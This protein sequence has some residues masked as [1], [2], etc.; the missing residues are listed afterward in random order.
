MPPKKPENS[1]L[2]GGRFNE[3]TTPFV[4]RFTASISFD[5]RLYQYDIDGSVAHAKMLRKVGILTD[6]EEVDIVNG[7]K[8]SAEKLIMRNLVGQRSLKIFI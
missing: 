4:E 8:I 2:W 6:K 7:L 1:K 3:P 5:K